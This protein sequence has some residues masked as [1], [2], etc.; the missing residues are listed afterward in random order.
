MSSEIIITQALQL[1]KQEDLDNKT[2][3]IIIP[4]TSWKFVFYHI[5][6]SK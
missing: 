6:L 3:I 2:T 4:G 5:K 1:K